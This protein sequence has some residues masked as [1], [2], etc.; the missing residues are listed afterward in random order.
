MSDNGYINYVRSGYSMTDTHG[1]RGD[2][3]KQ[4]IEYIVNEI[5]NQKL[6]VMTHEIQNTI[7]EIIN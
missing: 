5:V 3:H 1:G 2:L 4:E 6:E 7:N